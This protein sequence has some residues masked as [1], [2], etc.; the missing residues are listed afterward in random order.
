MFPSLYM[1]FPTQYNFNEYLKYFLWWVWGFREI[2]KPAYPIEF[3][4]KYYLKLY[5]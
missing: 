2:I 4:K 1:I 5:N 3:R